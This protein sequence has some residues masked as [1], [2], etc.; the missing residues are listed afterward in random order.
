MN[1]QIEAAR[2]NCWLVLCALPGINQ[3]VFAKHFLELVVQSL[4]ILLIRVL[5]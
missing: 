4:T 2:E 3:S 1:Q 5:H